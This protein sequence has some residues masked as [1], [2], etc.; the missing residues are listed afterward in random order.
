MQPYLDT[1]RRILTEGKRAPNR[2]GIDRIRLFGTQTRYDMADGFPLDTTREINVNALIEETLFFIS[3]SSRTLDLEEKGVKIW[4]PWTARE[5]D[6][7]F[8]GTP[9][10]NALVANDPNA[11]TSID[12]FGKGY[13][14]QRKSKIGTIGPM[15]G[16][17]WRH[18]DETSNERMNARF[19][20]NDGFTFEDIPSDFVA[21]L[22]KEN[23]ENEDLS[24]DERAVL[25]ELG[26]YK[27][28]FKE[29]ALEVYFEQGVDQLGNM[30]YN[31]KKHPYEARHCVT[32]W[33]P[34]YLPLY[35]VT[36]EE[37]VFMGFGALP[38]CHAF[39][40][41]F[42]EPGQFGQG[43][44][45]LSLQMYQRS[46]DL[47]VGVPYNIAEY[48]LIL[49]MIAHCLYMEPGDFIHATGD[50]HIYVNQIPQVQEQIQRTPGPLPRLW[51]NP[52]KRDLFS[53]TRDDIKILDYYP[54]EKIKCNVVK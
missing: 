39:F 32:A 13:T 54:Q 35:G 2:T 20:L 12:A 23:E 4:A 31:L 51:L 22:V 29:Y 26:S 1:M 15:Y 40:Q 14:E 42:V 10:Y 16:N 50:T 36:P 45:R 19:W 3:G 27:D 28:S 33:I 18:L 52:N 7:E 34:Q 8:K 17:V 53:F 25:N 6:A 46:C 47:Q 44:G 43:N 9:L 24:P 41:C 21:L 5:R 11:Q 38:P 49:S 37:N 30:M 48:S